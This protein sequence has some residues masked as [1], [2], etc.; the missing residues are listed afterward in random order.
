M[1][2]RQFHP[3]D[4]AIAVILP[5][6]WAKDANPAFYGLTYAISSFV[7]VIMN[8]ILGWISYKTSIRCAMIAAMSVSITGIL[9]PGAVVPRHAIKVRSFVSVWAIE[10]CTGFHV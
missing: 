7:P 6:G 10:I 4:V 8:P 3:P 1:A 9:Q 2:F 5:P